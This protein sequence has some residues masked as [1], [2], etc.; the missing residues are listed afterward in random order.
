V[1]SRLAELDRSYRR[2]MTVTLPTAALLLALGLVT[3]PSPHQAL[4][5]DR[6]VGFKGP[7]KIMPEL[8]ITPEELSERR[9]TAAPLNASNADFVAVEIDVVPEQPDEPEE[10]V[11]LPK[12]LDKDQV[13]V[14]TTDNVQDAIRTTG[15]P[16]PAQTDLEV[17]YA[18]RPV[19]PPRAVVKGIEGGVEVLLLVDRQGSVTTAYVVNPGRKPLLEEAARAAA[20]RYIFRPFKVDGKPT[21]FWVRL[22]FEFHLVS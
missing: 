19:Y 15:L 6:R 18:A 11:P 22:P 7:I 1:T 3:L 4:I 20:L 2:T 17:L 9:L 14:L 8:D 12:I 5:R 16:V 21:P 13:Q 10:P